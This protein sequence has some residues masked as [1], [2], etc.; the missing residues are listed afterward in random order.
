MKK[1]LTITALL[2]G[3]SLSTSA[4][5]EVWFVPKV[6]YGITQYKQTSFSTSVDIVDSENS[7]SEKTQADISLMTLGA[8][9]TFGVD[10]FYIDFDYKATQDS[11]L[12]HFYDEQAAE[13]SGGTDIID[14]GGLDRTEFTVTT[15]FGFEYFGIFGGLKFSK[16][17]LEH[18]LYYNIEGE[19]PAYVVDTENGAVPALTYTDLNSTALFAGANVQFQ[20]GESG[21]LNLGAAYA[22]VLETTFEDDWHNPNSVYALTGD[23]N[24]VSVSAT[25]GYGIFYA[26]A[27]VANYNYSNYSKDEGADLGSDEIKEEFTRLS[28][29]LRIFF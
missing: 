4:M 22:Q 28:A 7:E 5:A 16:S 23:G 12:H 17:R 25:L 9:A 19:Y 14:N 27:E 20:F 15:G 29:G 6:D 10:A 1:S 21:T 8:G 18:E 24:G 26:K 11:E 2:I 13:G 3:A